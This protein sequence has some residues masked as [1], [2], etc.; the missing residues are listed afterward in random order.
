MCGT[1]EATC[2]LF[3]TCLN[4]W[5]NIDWR[6]QCPVGYLLL[7]G[8]VPGEMEAGLFSSSYGDIKPNL[9]Q[10][11]QGPSREH[12]ASLVSMFEYRRGSGSGVGLSLAISDLQGLYDKDSS[13]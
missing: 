6:L 11:R 9:S 8:H 5:A 2:K 10:E 3:I 4:Y 1:R 7:P 12:R 13:S